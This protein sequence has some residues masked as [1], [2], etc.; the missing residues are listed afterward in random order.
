M[1]SHVCFLGCGALS[2]ESRGEEQRRPAGEDGVYTRLRLHLV[3]YSGLWSA[4]Q[5]GGRH[6]VDQ[7]F[8]PANEALGRMSE[9][10]VGTG[11]NEP[12]DSSMCL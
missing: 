1:C 12:S 5:D 8:L 6:R 9:W 2:G 10:F 11:A 4:G 3:F 7:A